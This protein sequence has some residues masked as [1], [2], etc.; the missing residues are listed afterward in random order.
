MSS[1]AIAREQ[2]AAVGKRANREYYM[3]G[4][5]YYYIMVLLHKTTNINL[6]ANTAHIILFLAR[7]PKPTL[8]LNWA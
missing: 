3:Q 4:G 6:V 2:A 7:K 1:F 5:Y 8:K